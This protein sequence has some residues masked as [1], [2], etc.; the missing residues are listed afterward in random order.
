M[1]VPFRADLACRWCEGELLSGDPALE[2]GGVS[3]D[4]RTIAKGD[5]FIAVR[6]PNHDSHD[7]LERALEAGAAGCLVERG[8]RTPPGTTAIAVDDTTL[9]LGALAAGHR[10]EFEGPVIAITGSNGKTTTKE[11]CAAI[12]SQAGPCLKNRG[13][14]N[15]QYGLPLTLLSREPEHRAAVVEIGMNHRGEIAP[16]AA[17]ARPTVGVITNIGTAHIE[18]LGSQE[19]I[20]LE[21]GDLFSGLAPGGLAV[22]NADDE[23]AAAQ[24]RRA[25][26]AVLSFGLGEDAD[27]RARD[28]E[29]AGLE[30]FCF[31]L[32][33]PQGAVDVRVSG[34]GETTI[35]NALAAAA[36]ALAA[37]FTLD[38]VVAGLAA[39]SSVRGRMEPRSA[40]G[41]RIVDDTYNAN[42]ESVAEALKSLGRLKGGRRA[43]AVLGDMG[44]LGD[45]ATGAHRAVG[46]LAARLE[47]DFLLALGEYAG[48]LADGAREAGMPAER[49]HV[50][51]S[52]LDAGRRV[53]ELLSDGDWVLV[54]GS[55]SMGMEAVVDALGEEAH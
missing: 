45:A 12:L 29:P 27:V 30:G 34:L 8:R 47:I 9:A 32:T 28:V 38:H 55:R 5:L 37:G 54:K 36:G 22:V 40:G 48:D 43:V 4:T 7:Y 39:H 16:L 18:H 52:H 46:A 25:P 19:E 17:I 41:L 21:K 24:A 50:E 51:S 11:M 23:L 49:I 13:N 31:R 14:L 33:A 53:R 42:P 6:G 20:A 35:P 10:S 2:L 15:N 3:I 44:E 26:G 1:S